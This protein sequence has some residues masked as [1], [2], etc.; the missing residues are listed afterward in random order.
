MKLKKIRKEHL[1]CSL[2]GVEIENIKIIIFNFHSGSD[3][4][5][6][7]NSEMSNT[8]SNSSL[9]VV[10]S[11]NAASV[12]PPK[13][14]NQSAIEASSKRSTNQEDE[15]PPLLPRSVSNQTGP[16]RPLPASPPLQQSPIR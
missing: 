12:L 5:I 9:P 2:N 16:N 13:P 4:N 11:D 7:Q 10:S 8:S 15:T 3:A 6:P 14:A 1:K